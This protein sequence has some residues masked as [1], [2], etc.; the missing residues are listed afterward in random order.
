MIRRYP[1]GESIW[2]KHGPWYVRFMH[3]TSLETFIVRGAV[4]G[5]LAGMR[6]CSVVRVAAGR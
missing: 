1:N 5:S 3:F 6:M 2:L 4:L